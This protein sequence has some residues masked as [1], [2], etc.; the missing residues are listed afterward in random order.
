MKVAV[1]ECKMG[2]YPPQSLSCG[3]AIA[4]GGRRGLVDVVV[5]SLAQ[6]EQGKR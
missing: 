1:Q 4:A 2:F 3:A 5:K 6:G